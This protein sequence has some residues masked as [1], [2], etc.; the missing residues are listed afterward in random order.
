MKKYQK[1]LKKITAIVAALALNLAFVPISYAASLTSLSDTMS[2]VK[3]STASNHTIKYN[4]PTGVAAGQTMT[5]TFPA[6]FNMSSVAFGDVDVSWGPSTGAENELTLAAAPSGATWGA[7]V[8]GQVL[9][10]T[11]GTGT[12]TVASK[13]IIEIGT[14]ATA[15]GTGVNQITNNPSAATYTF[16]IGGTFGDTGKIA[17]V[18]VTDDQVAMSA[19][20]DPSITFSLSANA[21]AFGS[22]ST[23]SVTTSSPNI[24]LTIGTNANSGYTL[25]VQDQG[26][27]A[28]AGLY[29]AG[30]SYNIASASALLAIGT[31]GYGIQAAS[32]TAT[33]P[34]PYNVSGNNVGQLQRTPQN[35]ATYNSSTSA[36]HTVTVT[37]LAAISA[38]T[39]AGSYADT[40]TYI[41]TGNF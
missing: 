37:H 28:A 18:I 13:V 24:T 39:K 8:A 31:E 7:A 4:T 12:M 35:L 9:T 22:L 19:S 14:N 17:V 10:I 16:S 38:S 6:G 5:V 3:I 32:A 33:I 34:G 30:A 25:T 26:S 1:T 11:S 41:A 23:G 27:G 2:R 20:V 40:L 29:N 36:S 15:G 21:S